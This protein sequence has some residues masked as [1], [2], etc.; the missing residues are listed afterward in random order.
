[1]GASPQQKAMQA[2]QDSV[3]RAV[4]I[5]K[6]EGK[7]TVAGLESKVGGYRD[8]ASAAQ[9]DISGYL[10]AG[11]TPSEYYSRITGNFGELPSM[12]QQISTYQGQLNQ[13]DYPVLGSA[14]HQRFEDTL[15]KSANIYTQFAQ[16]G[17]NEVQPR[18]A[19]LAMDPAFNLQR[20]PEAMKLAQGNLNESQIKRLTTYNV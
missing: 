5:A 9:Q 11:Q 12:P 3:E 16:R 14:A 2:A 20:D 7:R 17:V 19:G 10:G 15:G 4:K 18:F 6:K 13:G 8:L 1:M